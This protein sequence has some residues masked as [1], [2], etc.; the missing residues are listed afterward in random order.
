MK[1]NTKSKVIRL[2]MI[3]D[4]PVIF[5][6]VRLSL[7]QTRTQTIEFTSQ[8]T[9]GAEVLADLDK[10]NADV[11]LID[12]CL[13]DIKG[14]DLAARILE[15]HPTVKIGIFSSM[16]DK[17]CILNSFQNGVLGYLPKS[18]G[19]NEIL[20]FI[21]TI[22]RGERY[23]RG[24]VADVLFE[25]GRSSKVQEKVNLTKRE[26]EILE[27]VL[28]GLKNREIA[29]KLNIAERTVEFHKQNIYLKLDVTNSVELVKAAQRLNLISERV[30]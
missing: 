17:E 14:Y 7:K 26:S 27:L 25:N 30:L 10:L 16:L 13:P 18:A 29:D 11:I 1:D 4:H 5:W 6:G 12:M 8:Y 3:D 28:D 22:H 19:P 20:D 9:S 23:I 2:T 15:V 24:V 21:Q